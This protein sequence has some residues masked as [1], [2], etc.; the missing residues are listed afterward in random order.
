MILSAEAGEREINYQDRFAPP[1]P[2]RF[3]ALG[4]RG[5]VRL[6]WDR[7]NA[8]EVAGYF[9]FRRDPGRDFERLNTEPISELEFLDRGLSAGLSFDYRIQAIDE[10]GNLSDMSEPI[11]ATVR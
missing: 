11:A 7:S 5:S 2:A 4:E 10:V 3:V 1:L 6:R 8:N 9:L